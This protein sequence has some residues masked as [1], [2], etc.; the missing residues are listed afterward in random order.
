M[1]D[2]LL[3][4]PARPGVLRLF[5][6]L[7]AA[8]LLFAFWPRN[9]AAG[10][11]P[12][13]LRALYGDA[14]LA[15]AWWAA[16]LLALAALGTGLAPRAAG[17]TAFLLLL[18]HAFLEEGRQSRQVL[19]V[20]LGATALLPSRGGPIW[21]VR[22]V[23]IQLSAAYGVNALMK[24]TPHYLSG[25]ALRGMA[26]TLPN[27]RVDCADGVFRLGGISLPVA[28][29]AALSA[30][31]EWALAVGFWFPRLRLVVAILG[32]AFHL[33]LMQVVRIFMLDYACMFLYLAFLM[34]WQAPPLATRR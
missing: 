34:P 24:S 33:V 4:A 21:P 6:C 22:L 19:L 30:L 12:P 14:F 32:I 23:Q 13:L 8:M 9:L 2:R 31:A 11:M 27:W 28:A 15:L 18:P 1:I 3:F 17:A 26:E 20:A 5:R 29:A 25:D 16:V 10:A 7:L